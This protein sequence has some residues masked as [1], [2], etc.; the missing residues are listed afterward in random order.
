MIE[1]EKVRV[2]RIEIEGQIKEVAAVEDWLSLNHDFL[3]AL[4]LE[5]TAMAVILTLIVLV[6]AFN[7]CGS[8][9]M[10]VRDKTRDIAILKS[11][12]AFDKSVLKIF[13]YQGIFIGAVGTTVGSLLGVVLSFLLRDTIQFPLN[14]EVYMI[15]TLPVDLRV[16]D[17]G[18]VVVGA[19]VISLLATLY[20]ARLASQVVPTEGL[21]QDS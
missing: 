7:I 21:K 5:K 13:L 11:M 20:P 6:A 16:S 8:L 18:C 4:R 2:S 14:K 1:V 9:I 12:G 15:D 19:M 3:S 10:L 17:I